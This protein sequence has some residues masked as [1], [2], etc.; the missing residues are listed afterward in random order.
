MA[1]VM[2]GGDDGQHDLI[3]QLRRR[4]VNFLGQLALEGAADVHGDAEVLGATEFHQAG[5]AVGAVAKLLCRCEDPGPRR[6]ARAWRTTEHDGDQRRG[7]TGRVGDLTNGG[8]LLPCRQ[9]GHQ[10]YVRSGMS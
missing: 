7:D 4:C 1:L 5:G 3:A 2:C 9:L 6:L 8:R 10:R